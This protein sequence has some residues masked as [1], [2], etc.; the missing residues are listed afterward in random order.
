[1]KS[2]YFVTIIFAMGACGVQYTAKKQ[3][4]IMTQAITSNNYETTLKYTHPNV[5]KMVGGKKEFLDVLKTGTNEMKLMGNK[6]ESIEIGKPSKTVK[7]ANEIHCLIP[8]T[9]SMQ[10]KDGKMKHKSYLLAVSNDKGKSW[11]FIETALITEE[12]IYQIL[13]NYNKAL[14]IPEKGVPQYFK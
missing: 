12:S 3:A 4:V 9:I 11:T 8:E 1:M 6:Y 13:P 5:V 2:F 10:L 7:A 14:V